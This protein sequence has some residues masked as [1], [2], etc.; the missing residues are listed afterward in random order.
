MSD[1]PLSVRNASISFGERTVLNHVSFN[2]LPNRILGIAGPNG[3]GKTTLLRSLFGAQPLHE[4]EIRLFD[5]PLKKLK[6][7]QISTQ[8]AVVSQFEYDASRM[9]VWD[10]VMLGRA[11]HRKDMQG[12]SKVDVTHAQRALS[13]VGM[14]DAKDRYL[15]SLSGGERQRVLI[16]RALAQDCPCIVLDEPTNHL[17]ITYQHQ[18]LALIRELSTTA[19]IVLHDLNL[20][21]RYCD[22]VIVLKDGKVAC[23]GTPSDVLTPSTIRETYDIDTLE[24]RDSGMKQFIFRG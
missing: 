17:D 4:G 2:V 6:P 22:D 7:S 12:Y 13:L 14:S 1:F 9:R 20:V 23:Y 8:L 19:V 3:S 24:V 15:H 18:I 10:L 5:V 11:P 16:A 21:S